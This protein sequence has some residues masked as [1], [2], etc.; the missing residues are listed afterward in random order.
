MWMQGIFGSRGRLAAAEAPLAMPQPAGPAAPAPVAAPPHD[1][2]RPP[3]PNGT[4][5]G[6]RLVEDSVDQ[7]AATAAPPTPPAPSSPEPNLPGAPAAPAA[8]A[9]ARVGTGPA[10]ERAGPFPLLFPDEFATEAEAPRV[11]DRL[12][13][14]RP[15]ALVALGV[16]AG[17]AVGVGVA[18]L[19]RAAS[20]PR[21]S[22]AR[23]GGAAVAAAAPVAPLSQLAD[24]L[25][26]ALDA[27]DVRAQLF[28]RHQMQCADLARGLIV[29]EENWADYNVARG[30]ASGPL[31][32]SAAA[33]DRSLYARVGET[34]RRFQRS[35]CPRP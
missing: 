21:G 26:L 15:A 10:P 17:V 13:R 32:S 35:G 14:W 31:D 33:T 11:A 3:E 9:Q 29:V 5:P 25:G 34:A 1:A 30:R 22:D 4:P 18:H 20:P 12:V 19:F 23:G 24:T 6:P 8:P 2:E 16:V 28:E 7:Y 27:F